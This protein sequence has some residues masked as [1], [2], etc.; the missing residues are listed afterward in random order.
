MSPSKRTWFP[1]EGLFSVRNVAE[2][3]NDRWLTQ[4]MVFT[5]FESKETKNARWRLQVFVW[6]FAKS[7]SFDISHKNKWFVFK[8]TV[9][10]KT[11]ASFEPMLIKIKVLFLSYFLLI[12]ICVNTIFRISKYGIVISLQSADRLDGD[13]RKQRER[14]REPAA[15]F[16]KTKHNCW[17]EWVKW[18]W[19]RNYQLNRV[20]CHV[21]KLD[22]VQV[23]WG[24]V[25]PAT[26]RQPLSLN[27][28]KIIMHFLPE[29]PPQICNYGSGLLQWLL[30]KQLADEGSP[31]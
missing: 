11:T 25:A 7:Y 21:G 27:P 14:E 18:N 31:F 15:P 1:L 16:L 3:W 17:H 26:L 29:P 19:S 30:S 6:G 8:N 20:S 9:G 13:V 24:Y 22:L 12:L 28:I 5:R 23:H 4:H 2:H 10:T